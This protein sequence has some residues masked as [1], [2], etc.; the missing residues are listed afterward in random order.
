VALDSVRRSAQST[1]C[2]ADRT[3]RTLSYR[4]R[5]TCRRRDVSEQLLRQERLIAAGEKMKE[6]FRKTIRNLQ[7]RNKE[8]EQK[9]R[10]LEQQLAT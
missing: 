7:D 8:L 2:I 10:E 5:V 1:L 6:G 4:L 9:V 3:R